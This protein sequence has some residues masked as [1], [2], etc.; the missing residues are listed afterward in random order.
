MSSQESSDK[1]SLSLLLPYY[2]DKTFSELYR[3]IGFEVL[4]ADN[5][6][7]IDGV[8]SAVDC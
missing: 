4:W 5:K 6:E 8:K 7:S 3:K 1:D 2:L